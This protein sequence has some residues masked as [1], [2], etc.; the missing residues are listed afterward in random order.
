MITKVEVAEGILFT[1]GKKRTGGG[2]GGCGG[3]FTMV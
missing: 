2:S 1:F 3:G